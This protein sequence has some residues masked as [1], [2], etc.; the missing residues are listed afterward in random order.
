M[1]SDSKRKAQKFAFW[2]KLGLA[3]MAMASLSPVVVMANGLGESR[4]WQF[5]TTADKAN[6]AVV[7]DMIEKK[8]GGYYDGFDT[9]VYNTTNI[10]TQVNCNNIADAAGN[11]AEN[12]QGGSSSDI[13]PETA[14]NADSTGNDSTADIGSEGSSGSIDSDQENDGAIT[15]VIDGSS[16]SADVS[17]VDVG[18][19]AQDM[20]NDQDNS[21]DQYATVDSS[22][23]CYLEG[24]AIT[25][26]VDVEATG[27]LN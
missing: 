16:S 5:E 17:D 8:R 12:T 27:V 15:A 9:T 24:S 18:N 26:E 13:S 20:L 11:I 25:G 22:T 6:K 21:G 1:M 2:V 3:T 4:S 23:A 14:L 10:G 7:L 19:T